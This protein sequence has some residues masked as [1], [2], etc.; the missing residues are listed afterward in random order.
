MTSPTP[1]QRNHVTQSGNPTARKT[2]VFV[3]GFGTDQT[4]WSE[5][6][7]A[8][9]E[10]AR[11]IT[12]DLTG[13]G[14]SDP[15]AY[16]TDK[17]RYVTLRGYADDLVEIGQSLGLRDAV[18]VGHSVGGMVGLL[19]CNSQ[20]KI[21]SQL[22]LIGASPRY[23]DD[24]DYHGGL[25]QRTI[26]DIHLQMTSNYYGWTAEFAP[27]TMNNPDRPELAAY[28]A[29]HL[30]TI[31]VAHAASVLITILTSDYRE[32]VKKVAVPTLI[33]QSRN[34]AT[35]PLPVAEYLHQQI[36][37]SRLALI[38]SAGHLPHV[39][40]PDKVITAMKNFGL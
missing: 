4:V 6:S 8:F 35:V 21:F 18:L 11:I 27:L 25:T 30:Q 24:A 9:Q 34:D 28:F 3:H 22:V 38:D 7:A 17:N 23:L 40:A 12:L 29:A 20:P 16:E 1:L 37:H 14:K 33:I 36:P 13:A 10:H 39:S 26:S 5:V 2:L 19:A 15:K 32:D 31:P